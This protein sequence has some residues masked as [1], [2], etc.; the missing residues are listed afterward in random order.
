[1]VIL[2]GK[3]L[4]RNQAEPPWFL[5][6]LGFETYTY[7]RY[8]MLG[9]RFHVLALGAPNRDGSLSVSDSMHRRPRVVRVLFVTDVEIDTQFV[10]P[11]FHQHQQVVQRR[12]LYCM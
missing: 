2:I 9:D 7:L 8:H 6:E 4:S 3:H 12:D 11:V 5:R 1:M 10:P